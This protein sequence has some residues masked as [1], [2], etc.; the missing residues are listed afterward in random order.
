MSE[1]SLADRVAG[2]DVGLLV[3]DA[4]GVPY[5][6]HQPAMLPPAPQIEMEP[7]AGFSRSHAHV[8]PGTWSDDGAQALCLLAT[9]LYCK[10]LDIENFGCR[11]INWCDLGYMAVDGDVFDIGNTTSQALS[12]LRAGIPA[13]RS[14]L[15]SEDSNGN[16]ALMRVLPLA[17]WHKGTDDELVT[18][19][20]RSSLVTHG[21]LRSQVCCAIYCLWAR[22][23]LQDVTDP[24]MDAVK[25]LKSIYKLRESERSEL[26]AVLQWIK[27]NPPKGT[28]YVVDSLHSARWAASQGSFE[29]ALKAAIGLGYD[30]DTTACIAGGIAG[31]SYGLSGIPLRWR[32]SLREFSSVEPMI[33]DLVSWKIE[34]GNSESSLNS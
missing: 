7:P 27:N 15:A 20:Q 5:E 25:T 13:S 34:G 29:A 12:R 21:H 32:T 6:F 10:S 26:D 11:L 22:R 4:L 18:D 24:W 14:G 23:I 30:T 8:P 28:G 31:I 9:L 2:G 3:G 17:L 19:A 16:G 33:K 1:K